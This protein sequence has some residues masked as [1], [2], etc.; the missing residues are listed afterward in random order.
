MC[1]NFIFPSSAP[2]H[3]IRYHFSLNLP[4][5][6]S[7]EYRHLCM[8]ACMIV[9]VCVLSMSDPC[10]YMCVCIYWIQQNQ[11]F[12]AV[13][14]WN[15]LICIVIVFTFHCWK[16]FNLT[17]FFSLSLIF[18][19]FISFVV[20]WRRIKLDLC[21]KNTQ[22]LCSVNNEAMLKRCI[23]FYLA[24]NWKSWHKTDY[25]SI[26]VCLGTL[27]I[28]KVTGQ[29]ARRIGWIRKHERAK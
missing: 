4:F 14:N 27:I 19:F 29:Q 23:A 6:C 9:C 20:V 12:E 8:H 26:F 15:W 3:S 7:V 1:F 22:K 25:M 5:I 16:M 2:I 13:F 24:I 21:A 28:H 17:L 18:F 10:L 11:H